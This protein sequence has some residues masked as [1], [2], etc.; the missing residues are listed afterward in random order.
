MF[1]LDPIISHASHL[2]PA[3]MP[4]A[5]LLSLGKAFGGKACGEGRESCPWNQTWP[6]YKA[7]KIVTDMH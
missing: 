7:H 3:L 5:C 1:S 4:L 6:Y 2:S